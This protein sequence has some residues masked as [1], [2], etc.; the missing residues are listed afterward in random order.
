MKTKI[1]LVVIIF[2]MGTISGTSIFLMSKFYTKTLE[3]DESKLSDDVTYTRIMRIDEIDYSEKIVR[4]TLLD[5]HVGS[6]NSVVFLVTE[7]T[8]IERQNPILDN[9]VVIGTS[10]IISLSLQDLSKDDKILIRLAA[11][12]DGVLYARQIIHGT[13]FPR[14]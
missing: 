5:K 14:L 9:D 4:A 7:E 6:Q 12:V 11:Q 1:L 2:S 8:T 3:Q 10:P 13:P